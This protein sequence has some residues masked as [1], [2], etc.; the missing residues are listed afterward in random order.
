[1][2]SKEKRITLQDVAD[3]A[4]VSR[5]T[6]SLVVRGSK[7]IKPS[8]HKKVLDSMEK[9]GYVYD[10]VAASFRSQRSST[11]GV[12]VTD[13]ENPFYP[14]ILA[15]IEHVLY[16]QR[17]NV[18]LGMSFE[19]TEKQ[20]RVLETMLEHRVCGIIMTPVASTPPS[21]FTKL[22]KRNIP[23]LLIGREVDSVSTDYVG[24]DYTLGAKMAVRHLIEQ[25]HRRI[26]YLGGMPEG[27]TSYKERFAGYC[28]ALQQFGL[29]LDPALIITSSINREGGIHAVQEAMQL[30]NPPT[31]CF[32]NNDVIALGAMTG[33][34]LQGRTP[35]EHMAIV[36]FDNVQET[37]T[38]KPGL[39]TVSV[40]QDKWGSEAAKLLLKRIN[41]DQT[42]PARIII[43]PQLIVRESST[44]YNGLHSS[45]SILMSSFGSE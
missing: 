26:A 6:A 41:G 36:G 8:T 3:D 21:L 30:D 34:R 43:P 10:R 32:C 45:K 13:I 40:S 16:E 20:E 25:G 9:L 7:S 2:V 11:I 4:G 23:I 39:S 1:M 22:Q 14:H 12:I 42:E 24:T 33:M 31:A 15:H 5:A 27:N 18:L 19:S 28:E 35:G 17:F 44:T 29:E 38:A 37:E